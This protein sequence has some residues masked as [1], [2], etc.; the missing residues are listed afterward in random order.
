MD[1]NFITKLQI[2]NVRNLHGLTID[3]STNERKNLILTGKNGSGKT[4]VLEAMRL[5]NAYRLK[6]DAEIL[7]LGDNPLKNQFAAHDGEMVAVADEEV[8]DMLEE[9]F[10]KRSDEDLRQ[11]VESVSG[12]SIEYNDLAK[13][14]EKYLAGEFILAYYPAEREYAVKSDTVTKQ[15]D[16]QD[17][18]RISESPGLDF[19]EYMKNIVIKEHMY[20]YGNQQNT[21]KA[22]AYK[23]KMERIKTILQKVYAS[24]HVALDFDID[25]LTFKI[26][27]PGKAPYDFNALPSGYAAILYIVLDLIMRMEK[28][29]TSAYDLEGIVMI[30]EVDAHL[31]LSMQ[32]TILHNLTDLF[33][34]IQFIVSTHSP[35]VLSSVS[36]AIVYDLEGRQRIDSKEGLSNLPYSGIVEGYFGVSELSE[37][38][39]AK[40]ERYKELAKKSSFSD[41]DYEELGTLESYLDEIPDFLALEIMADYRH[42]RAEIEAREEERMA[43]G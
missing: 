37:K 18:Y 6:W 22:D 30:D 17:M 7:K 8:N 39:K 21:A 26:E 32:R 2:N 24:S 11:R 40:F 33:P 25:S 14:R 43:N 13:I 27:E 34:N 42:I 35:F 19:V 3:L 10:E 31:H 15:V 38:L 28:K 16:L 23:G 20:R 9:V 41:D 1:S 29:I 5:Y 4:S 36:N 12:I